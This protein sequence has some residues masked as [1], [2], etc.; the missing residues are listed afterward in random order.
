MLGTLEISQESFGFC[1]FSS[2]KNLGAFHQWGCDRALGQM[3]LGGEGVCSRGHGICFQ[4]TSF[5][6]SCFL[7]FARMNNLLMKVLCMYLYCY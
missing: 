4:L 6:W 2:L 5:N 3:A 1:R 7:V